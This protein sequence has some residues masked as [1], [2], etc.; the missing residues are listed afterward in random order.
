MSW[1]KGGGSQTHFGAVP[2]GS[3]D[4]HWGTE[5]FWDFPD[6][7]GTL[8]AVN[9]KLCETFIDNELFVSRG[10]AKDTI[11]SR[12]SLKLS[13]SVVS[14]SASLPSVRGFHGAWGPCDPLTQLTL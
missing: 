7:Y 11:A 2:S 9:M 6:A 10:T 14:L 8:G 5:Q 3:S 13:L 12:S 4:W 1:R